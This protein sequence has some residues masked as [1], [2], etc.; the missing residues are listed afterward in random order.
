MDTA[1]P[2]PPRTAGCVL[3][4]YELANVE[5]VPLRAQGLEFLA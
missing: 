2:L 4:K 3:W 1:L 5:P